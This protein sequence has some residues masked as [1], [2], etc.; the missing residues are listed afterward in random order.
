MVPIWSLNEKGQITV[1]AFYK[2]NKL[3][4]PW[5]K[6]NYG[7][8]E[9][10]AYYTDGVLNGVYQEF[11]PLNGRIQKEIHYNMGVQDG[12]FRYFNE[13]GK[14]NM[15]YMYKNGEKVSGGIVDPPKEV[16]TK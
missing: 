1:Q 12:L 16:P 11:D 10:S 3:D 13:E 4:G 2:N 6:F 5:S 9:T 8:F 14:I 7:R 15:E